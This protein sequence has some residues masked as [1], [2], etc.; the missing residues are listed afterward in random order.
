MLSGLWLDYIYIFFHCWVLPSAAGRYLVVLWDVSLDV[1]PHSLSLVEL[2][3]EV[4]NPKLATLCRKLECP[5]GHGEARTGCVVKRGT[6]KTGLPT[7]EERIKK[8]WQKKLFNLNSL[9][10]SEVSCILPLCVWLLMSVGFFFNRFIIQ[11]P[12]KPFFSFLWTRILCGLVLNM[13]LTPK[14]LIAAHCMYLCLPWEVGSHSPWFPDSSAVHTV[15]TGHFELK[16]VGQLDC[17]V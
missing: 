4:R 7:D 16:P 2:V 15:T 1:A 14:L 11:Q 8:W 10:S 6:D 17:F 9:L 3:R 12:K 5:L 13:L